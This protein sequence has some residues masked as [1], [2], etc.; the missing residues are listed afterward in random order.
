LR[1]YRPTCV[2]DERP[3]VQGVGGELSAVLRGPSILRPQHFVK[4]EGPYDIV[5]LLIGVNNQFRGYPEI[6]Y[7]AEFA[8]LL[9]QAIAFAGNDTGRVLVLSIPDY[10]VTPFGQNRNPEKIAAELDRYNLIADSVCQKRG[11]RFYDITPI[12]R[13]A[14]DDPDLIASDQLHPSGEMYRRWVELI[15]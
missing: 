6:Q 7:R 13:E 2:C 15:L 1:S 3:W 9:D 12:S 4:P 10:G 11:V 5:S 14:L 8:K